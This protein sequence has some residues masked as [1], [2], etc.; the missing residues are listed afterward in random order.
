VDGNALSR[1]QTSMTLVVAPRELLTVTSRYTTS[2][3]F[4][5]DGSLVDGCVG[6]AIH[7]TEEGSF[8]Y[9]ISSPVDIFTDELTA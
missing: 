1:A 4:Y 9:K 7:R 8:A 2:M 3:V 6:F 5:T